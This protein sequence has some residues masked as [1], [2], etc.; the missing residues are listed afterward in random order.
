MFG[1]GGAHELRT[2]TL[3]TL[4]LVDFVMPGDLFEAPWGPVSAAIGYQFRQ[5][6]YDVMRNTAQETNRM[7]VFQGGGTS[8]SSEQDTQAIFGELST[9][10]FENVTV[11]AAVRWEDYGG[12]IGSSV[13]PSPC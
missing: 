7:Y 11:Q 2:T 5:E 8:F 3:S 9:D 13:D 4:K 12:N 10:P 6:E 1:P